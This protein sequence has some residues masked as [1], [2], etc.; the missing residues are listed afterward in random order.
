MPRTSSLFVGRLAAL[1]AVGVCTSAAILC[2]FGYHA[3]LEWRRSS[4]L[5]AERRSNQAAELLVEALTR[6]MR[7]AQQF[8]LTSSSLRDDRVVTRPYQ[9][10]SLVASAF[11]RYPY[12]ESFF[13]WNG[14]ADLG[15]ATFFN[16]SDRRPPWATGGGDTNR[17]PVVMDRDAAMLNLVLDRVSQDAVHG[18]E[19]SAFEIEVKHVP[20]QVVAFLDY[21]DQFRRRLSHV[22]GFTVNLP[23]VEKQ[24]FSDLTTQVW[25]IGGAS[26]NGLRLSVTDQHGRLVAGSTIADHSALT[27]RRE[28]PMVFFD[29]DVMLR[30]AQDMPLNLWAVEVTAVDDASM[31]QAIRGANRTLVIGAAAAL[32]LAV[33]L[34]LT[35]RAGRA[36]ASLAEMRSDFVSTVT[37]ELKT[38]IATIRAAAE[39]LS[40]GRLTGKRFQ[41]Y[42]RLVNLEAKRLGRLV[43]NLLAYA[44]ITDV[45]DVYAFEP[46]QV[47]VLFNDIQQ[48]FEAQLDEGGFDLQINI[49][50]G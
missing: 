39:T 29:P 48:E 45:A 49:E 26:G 19:W 16:R 1:F 18:L 50:P 11:A 41:D 46:L 7:G 36:S 4:M 38:P 9:V 2:W 27:S 3:I 5:L 37:H 34:L 25:E 33:G 44:R 21:S 47:G 43:E 42:C 10:S 6:D 35:V 14:G 24:Y 28:F 40:K 12:P 13:V 20:Y 17:F 30:A 31:L 23:W 15:D 8:V 22:A 32:M